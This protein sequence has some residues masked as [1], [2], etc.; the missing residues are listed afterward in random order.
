MI[1]A[2]PGLARLQAQI[3]PISRSELELGYDEPL[4]G[5]DP[6]GIYAFYYYNDP[7]FVNTNLAL[8]VV[9][10]PTYADSELGLKHLL[11]PTTDVGIDVNGGGFL[12]NYYEVRQ[13]KYLKDQ[14]FDG[15]GAGPAL[16][17]YQL[18]DPGRLIPVDVVL[19]S[20]MH[21]ATYD[22]D[23]TASSFAIPGNQTSLF[24]R[25]GVRVA[26]TQPVLY[27]D[28]GLELS[29][30]YEHDWRLDNQTYGFDNDR[31][32]HANVSLFW[33]YGGLNYTFTNTAQKISFSTMVAGSEDVDRFGAWRLGGDLPLN[34]EF[35]VIL[36]GYYYQEL[37]AREFA[38]FYGSYEFP[39][40]PSH[41]FSFRT[42]AATVW[43][44]ALSRFEQ[45]SDWDSG[46]GGALVF[47]PK[48][49]NFE[50][51]LRYGYGFNA[52]RDGHQGAQSIGLLFQYNFKA[53]KNETQ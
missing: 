43:L 42:E 21:Y 45:R 44:G 40:E 27:P 4:E 5:Q 25:V 34:A 8:R 2:L 46:A 15:Y 52:I 37:A 38:Y 13:G 35:P 49:K 30:W 51:V 14:S 9:V 29:V 6:L 18:L 41:R 12:D 26:G 23:N 19:R 47:A 28:L 20:G 3:D 36:P 31:S 7:N 22:K 1:L 11:S 48:R 33:L 24:S 10:G 50:I 17:V 53:P 39:L 16:N 32:I